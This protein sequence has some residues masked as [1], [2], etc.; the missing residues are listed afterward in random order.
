[1][2]RIVQPSLLML[3][4][5]LYVSFIRQPVASSIKV[6]SSACIALLLLL[7]VVFVILFPFIVAFVRGGKFSFA[8]IA[9]GIISG[10]VISVIVPVVL[11]VVSSFVV[12]VVTSA[13]FLSLF[14][15]E[16]CE[17]VLSNNVLKFFGCIF[18]LVVAFE[19]VG[20]YT[21]TV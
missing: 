16:T 7:V 18:F 5:A 15:V 9:V 3:V 2:S 1:M 20:L 13:F 12:S 19:T 4:W 21:T 8:T 17:A 14:V 11:G 6:R 10:V